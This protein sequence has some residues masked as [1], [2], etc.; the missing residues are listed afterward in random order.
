MN[1]VLLDLDTCALP[2]FYWFFHLQYPFFV[3]LELVIIF[4]SMLD[5]FIIYI[6]VHDNLYTPNI[7]PESIGMDF[8][9]NL[10]PDKATLIC[11]DY[12]VE[13]PLFLVFA[14]YHYK[15]CTR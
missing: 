11:D 7:A 14:E 4:L 1:H 15:I 8:Q 2:C 5:S 10:L 3:F 12:F 13:V 9:T 6:K